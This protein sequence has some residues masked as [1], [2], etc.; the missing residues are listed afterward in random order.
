M[1]SRARL[2][3]LGLPAVGGVLVALSAPPFPAAFLV[4][5]FAGL[6][7]LGVS[8]EGAT[9]KGAALRGLVFGFFTNLVVFRF[10]VGTIT[11]FTDLPWIAA[12]LA[13]VLLA[14][15]QAIAWGVAAIAHALLRRK[16]SLPLSLAGGA[17]LALAVPQLF[18]W[19][20]GAPL[21]RAPV[22]MQLAEVVGE[23]GLSVIVAATAGFVAAAW[24]ARGRARLGH[25]AAALAIVLALAAYGA[26]RAGAVDE[27]AERATKARVALVQHAVAPKLRWERA[28]SS[29]ILARLWK[30]TR[31][32]DRQGATLAIWP[33][34]AYPWILPS[35]PTRDAGPFRIRPAG[36]K[37]EVL[38]GLLTDA[39]SPPGVEPGTHFHYNAATL[40]GVDGRTEPVAAKIELLAFG[41]YVPLGDTFPWLQRTFAR[42]GGLLPGK[43]VVLLETKGPGPKVRAGVLNCYEDTLPSQARRVARAN[44]NLLVNLT[45]DAWFGGGAEPELHL[46]EAIPRAIELRRALVRAVNTGVTSWIDPVGRVVARAPREAEALLVVDVPLLDSTPTPY[47]RVGDLGW[48]A[49]MVTALGLTVGV[50]KLD[51]PHSSEPSSPARA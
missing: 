15:G 40:V 22:L 35:E 29:S 7:L 1:S 41:E 25:S 20:I 13:L 27:L 48:I 26:V 36:V 9:I 49:L 21:A 45:N 14:L 19:T 24:L 11:E 18:V 50:R 37:L 32:A 31:E 17:A 44:P 12:D 6:A 28:A 43:D 3:G 47:E 2:L 33:E 51:A 4:L 42:G 5:V 34:A 16:A 23:R 38:T 8:L 46:L 10:V 30:L 39:P